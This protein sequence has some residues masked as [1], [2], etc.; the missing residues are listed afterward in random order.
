MNK[1][2]IKQSSGDTGAD[3]MFDFL[4]MIKAVLFAYALS[5]LLLFVFALISTYACLS[6]RT[7]RV[8]VNLA[9]ALGTAS[10]GFLSGRRSSRG[11]LISG[12]LC[13]CA[14]TVFLCVIGGLAVQNFEL[15]MNAVTAFTIGLVCGSV[16][17]IIGINTK[18][19]RRR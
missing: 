7:I 12:A 9:T 13:G 17:G 14:Y 18:S 16:G 5:A 2:L 11:G 1:S 19:R 8:L 3:K 15:G 10:C 4:Y 6:D